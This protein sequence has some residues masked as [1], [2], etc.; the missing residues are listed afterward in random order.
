MFTTLFGGCKTMGHSDNNIQKRRFLL[1]HNTDTRRNAPPRP[2]HRTRRANRTSQGPALVTV[3][4][5]ARPQSPH[6]ARKEIL[7]FSQSA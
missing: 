4:A 7:F 6:H 1:E 3:I 2:P 5:P